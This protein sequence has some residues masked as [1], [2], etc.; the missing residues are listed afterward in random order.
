M[1]Y[2]L[3]FL[4]QAELDLK[5]LKN[6]IIQN[7]SPNIWQDTYSKL[8]KTIG[9]LKKFPQTGNILPELESLNLSQYRQVVSGMNR[10]IY[11][12]QKDTLYIHVI[13]DC[14][15]NLKDLLIRRLLRTS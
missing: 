7:F 11:E 12:I 3:I 1:K 10:V 5:E 2:K 15:R 8:K 4:Y 6:Y 14:R 13:C 9:T